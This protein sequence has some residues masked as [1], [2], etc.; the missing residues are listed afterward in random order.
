MRC[1]L[2][3]HN[4]CTCRDLESVPIEGRPGLHDG[5]LLGERDGREFDGCEGPLWEAVAARVGGGGGNCNTH[6]SY[7][8]NAGA[9]K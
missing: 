3:D 6:G 8:S 5:G 4:I 1:P 7:L 9:A 2:K